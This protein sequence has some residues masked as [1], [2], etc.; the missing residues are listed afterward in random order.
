MQRG[1]ERGGEVIDKR[2]NKSFL[3]YKS[4]CVVIMGLIRG[5][6]TSS[7]AVI[8]IRVDTARTQYYS[9]CRQIE[10]LCG[11]ETNLA[12]LFGTWQRYLPSKSDGLGHQQVYTSVL[13]CVLPVL[14]AAVPV[15]CAACAVYCLCCVPTAWPRQRSCFSLPLCRAVP[16]AAGIIPAP[17]QPCVLCISTTSSGL[18]LLGGVLLQRLRQL[19]SKPAPSV[20]GES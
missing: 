4:R 1:G 14:C 19:L 20:T 6:H 17:F 10:R 9:T 16:V 18:C 3:I 2:N 8:G 13:C 5:D 11:E 7:H 12:N 15:L